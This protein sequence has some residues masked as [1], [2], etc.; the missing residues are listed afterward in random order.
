MK[1]E[2]VDQSKEILVLVPL[3]ASSLA[4]CARFASHDGC[5]VSAVGAGRGLALGLQER[6]S[7]DGI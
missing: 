4:F 5:T 1:S 3:R 2:A 6:T 7:L